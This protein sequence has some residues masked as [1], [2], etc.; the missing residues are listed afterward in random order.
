MYA[1]VNNTADV[2]RARD[3]VNVTSGPSE[4]LA[5]VAKPNGVV[6][7]RYGRRL[8]SLLPTHDVKTRFL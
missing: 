5:R 4:E 2:A 3:G 6:T 8:P 1:H 7:G